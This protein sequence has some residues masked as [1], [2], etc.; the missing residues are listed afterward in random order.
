MALA[1]SEVNTFLK[2]IENHARARNFDQASIQTWLLMERMEAAI[3]DGSDDT[4]E[5]QKALP[6]IRQVVGDC[7]RSDACGAVDH[8]HAAQLALGF[9]P[10]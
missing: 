2:G 4:F 8:V 1:A 7:G 10:E 6:V 9:L 3:D 5:F